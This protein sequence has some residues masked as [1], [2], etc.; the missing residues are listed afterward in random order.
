M[1]SEMRESSKRAVLN[2]LELLWVD[3]FNL[4]SICYRL[5]GG[6]EAAIQFGNSPKEVRDAVV[7][8]FLE[9]KGDGDVS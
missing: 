5:R 4:E 3:G 6:I 1:D 2:Q 7:E 8:K 9:L